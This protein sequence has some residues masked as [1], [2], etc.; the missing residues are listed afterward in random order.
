MQRPDV[1]SHA[2]V[3]EEATQLAETGEVQVKACRALCR[4]GLALTEM[5]TVEGLS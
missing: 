5:G 1:R 2:S 3:L 4:V